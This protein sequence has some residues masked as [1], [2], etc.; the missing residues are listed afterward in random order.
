MIRWLHISDLHFNDDD[1]STTSLREGL[2][3]FL[4][5]NHMKCD[6]VICTGDI[7]T[8]NADPNRFTDE[9]A[10]YL[11]DICHVVGVDSDRLFIVP[12]NHD[13]DRDAV[14]RDEA[15]KKICFQKKGYYDPRYGKIADEDLR[16]VH[17]GNAEF[18]EFLSKVY[19]T[20]PDRVSKYCDPLVPHFNIETKDFN[21]LHIDS[22]LTYTKDQEAVDLVIGTKLLQNAL[23]TLNPEK[24]TILLSHY[25]FTALLQ[26]EKKYVRELLYRK[27][28]CLWLAGHEHDHMVHP[29][30]Y[31]HSLQAGELRM[32]E[33]SNATVLVGEYDEQTY[34]GHVTAYTWFTEGWAKYPILWHDGRSEDQYS[35]QLRLPGDNGLSREAVKAKQANQEYLDRISIIDELIPAI[36]EGS[37]PELNSL[38]ESIWKS[39][40]P[41]LILLADGGMGKTTMLLKLCR[42]SKVAMLYIP[43]E[44]LEAIGTSIKNYCARVLFDGDVPKFEEFVSIKYAKPNLILLVDGLNEVN[45][46]AERQFINELKG[47][48]L[49]SGIQFVVTS[50]SDFTARYSMLGYRVR[51]L[52]PLS[53]KKIETIFSSEE[54]AGI[55][56][57]VTL[58]RLLSNPMMVTMYKAIS[59]IIREYKAEESLRWVLPIKNATDLLQNYY[60]AQIAVL[61]HRSGVDGQKAQLA[62]QVV[63]DVLPAIAYEFEATHSL[64]KN[65]QDFRSVLNTIIQAH[66]ADGLALLLL[67]ERFRDYE[68]PEMKVGSVLDYL[69]EET[70]L[71]YKDDKV[72]AFPHQIYRDFLSA[73]WITRQ[74]DL[75]KYWNGR[76]LPF[77]VME[78]I[79][80]L[81]G[82][83]WE[84]LAKQVHEAGKNRT[85]AFHLTG[86]LLDCFPYT[87]YSGY[88]DYSG[89][90]LRGLQI[91]GAYKAPS[92]CIS[93]NGAI[94]DKVSIG[95]YSSKLMHYTH[96]RFSEGNEF[97]AAVSNGRVFVFSLQ[98]EEEPFVYS[99][100]GRISRLSFVD[101]YLFATV[102]G[103]NASIQVFLRNEEWRYVGELKNPDEEHCSIFNN[104]FRMAILRNDVLHFYYN[105]REV[106]FDLTD[107][108]RIY[109]HQKQHAWEI[110]VQGTD[111]SFLKEKDRQHRNRNNGTL[112][113]TENNGLK[114]VSMLDGGLT[115]TSGVEIQHVLSRGITLLKDGAISGDGK[116]AATL[117]YDLEDGRRRTQIWDL[118]QKMRV[119]EILCLDSIEKIH[120][121]EDGTFVIGET[122]TDS[123]VYNRK[124]GS[125]KWYSEHFVSNQHGK[126]S[127]YGTK[128][129]RKNNENDLYLYDLENGE[130]R[131]TDNP[132][133]N[134]RLACFMSDGSIAVVGNNVRKVKF[135]NIRTGRYSEVNSQ[136]VPVIGISSFKNEPFIAV[137]T[138]DNIISI[139]H[140]GDCMRKRIFDKTGGNYLMIV[141]PE[142]T[143]IACSNGQK[144]LQTFNYYEKV[145][146]GKR[147]GW[148]YPNPYSK[149]DPAIKGDV[150]DLSFNTENKEL[151]VILS[152]GQIMFCHEKYCRYHGATEIITNFNVNAYDF[153]GCIC[154]QII[155]DQ[156]RQ[157][158][159][160]I[161]PAD[162]CGGDRT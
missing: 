71:L 91:P 156:I 104:R 21:I 107:G 79:R 111:V 89:L 33:R 52:E 73:Y 94:I 51:H 67:Q 155:R 23:A 130:I 152:N 143:V 116:C 114:A 59:P 3:A 126:I 31:F 134:A 4:K 58:H 10:E 139:Y 15:V 145:A 22:T 50:R 159:G 56:D 16:A 121:S 118:D 29:V 62:Y 141:S 131:E 41:H 123:W 76:K 100:G 101:M 64:N 149:E 55:K 106:Q 103:L 19:I 110:P 93:L 162:G 60:V 137:A 24:P 147:M 99:I 9:A 158:G 142:N 38:L 35:F 112:W 144:S 119:G 136:N 66:K 5:R 12:G 160:L 154:D 151:V 81:S 129:L 37:S 57:T 132:C 2:L 75:E 25:P 102:D 109:N 92:G 7:R 97:L 1:M 124:D 146:G 18:R 105:N 96:L 125:E 42:D 120:M 83:Y 108:R 26:D 74:T 14:G 117:S 39:F 140:I 115:I 46:R 72:T 128:V 78:H 8:A 69:I 49:L 138:Q 153:R 45:A 17:L 127:T 54:W 34:T 135:K 53:D 13:V 43:V 82:K 113:C 70:H 133:K 122:S 95:K 148:W 36:D 161:E 98:T 47:L 85:D 44:K 6:Y 63:F 61:L 20:H 40:T 90:D 68:V 88:P 77:P 28:V 11:V 84:G 157:N 65:N 30:D 150:L 87:E 80:N 48:N 27:G 86:N 32:E